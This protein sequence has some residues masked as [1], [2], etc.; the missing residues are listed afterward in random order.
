MA[1]RTTISWGVPFRYRPVRC[2]AEEE[3]QRLADRGAAILRAERLLAQAPND[4][5]RR[6]DSELDLA[7]SQVVEPAEE[8]R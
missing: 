3:G 2:Q 6:G 5:F 8:A 7:G 1:K 4:A